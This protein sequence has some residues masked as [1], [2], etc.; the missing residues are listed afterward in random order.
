MITSP[1]GIQDVNRIRANM[2]ILPQMRGAVGELDVA[3]DD[4]ERSMGLI[5]LEAGKEG[6]GGG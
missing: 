5:A 3:L 2:V 6:V 4:L 1:N